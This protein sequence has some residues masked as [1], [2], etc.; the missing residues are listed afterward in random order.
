[1]VLAHIVER[2]GLVFCSFF[3]KEESRVMAFA[4]NNM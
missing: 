1:M 3:R 4:K 2:T